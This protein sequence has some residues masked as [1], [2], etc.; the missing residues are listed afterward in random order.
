MLFNLDRDEK[1][2]QIIPAPADLFVKH[3][4]DGGSFATR[5]V[6]LGLIVRDD[7]ERSVVYLDAPNTLEIDVV[8]SFDDEIID[9]KLDAINAGLRELDRRTK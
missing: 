2:L 9:E 1:L 4:D 5:I 6:A 7:G 8:G 3:K